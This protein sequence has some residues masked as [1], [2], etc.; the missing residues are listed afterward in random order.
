SAIVQADDYY[1]FGMTFNGHRR[2]N[3]VLNKYLY[4]GKEEQELTGW[5]DYGWRMYE[6]A[7]ARWHVQE[8]LSERYY[9]Q[10]RYQY[11]MNNPIS[12]F[13]PDGTSTHTDSAGVV[14]A[15]YDDNDNSVYKHST[16][17]ESY[18]QDNAGLKY[19]TVK[20][21]DGNK[22]KVPTNKLSGGENMGETEYWDEFINPET[23]NVMTSTTI[24]FGKSWGP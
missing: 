6:Q 18:A 24:Q 13:D 23:S 14:I 12:F 10:S 11:V 19:K 5:L 15:V 1:P 7:I 22:K 17:P 20:D 21:K 16:L 3:S 2:E 4:N 8:P 9:A